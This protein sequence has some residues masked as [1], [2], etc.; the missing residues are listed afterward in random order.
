[1]STQKQTVCEACN[2]HY[3]WC[4]G[5]SGYEKVEAMIAAKINPSEAQYIYKLQFGSCGLPMIPCYLCNYSGHQKHKSETRLVPDFWTDMIN[6]SGDSVDSDD[7]KLT[8]TA[9]V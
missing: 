2:D 5:C 4:R 6:D 3:W 1:M 7:E 9:N 8:I